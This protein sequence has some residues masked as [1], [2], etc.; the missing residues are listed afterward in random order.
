M[1]QPC[2]AVIK[3][4]HRTDQCMCKVPQPCSC[5][6]LLDTAS[7]LGK[8]TTRSSCRYQGRNVSEIC[9]ASQWQCSNIE[10]SCEE[11]KVICS[12]GMV[13]RNRELA[14]EPHIA[15]EIRP[16][17]AKQYR[18]PAEKKNDKRIA[19]AVMPEEVRDVKFNNYLPDWEAFLAKPDEKAFAVGEM[20]EH[21]KSRPWAAAWDH[22]TQAAA[23]WAAIS[24]CERVAPRCHLTYPLR[25]AGRG[26]SQWAT[27]SLVPGG[28]GKPEPD[29]SPR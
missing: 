19:T 28:T 25:Q 10:L 5:A 13:S 24:A 14:Q 4:A 9:Q 16:E 3:L 29:F 27:R 26:S 2:Q 8:D 12:S 21:L 18:P 22:A 11:D 23:N 20:L 1:L 15:A 17:K 6:A 7:C